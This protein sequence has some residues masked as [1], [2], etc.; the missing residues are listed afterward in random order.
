MRW[1][2][3]SFAWPAAALLAL[4]C[5]VPRVG[6]QIR[7]G[8][9]DPW[10]LGKGDWIYIL[11]DASS[12]HGGLAGLMSYEKSK[13]VSYVI[14]KA[15]EG[16]SLYA[17]YGSVQFN[18]AAVTAAHNAGLK[19][20][21]YTRSYGTDIAGEKGV[22]DYVFNLGADGFVID[23]EI[24][25][26]SVPNNGT[27]A[28]NLCSSI[29]ASWPNKFLAHAPMPIISVHRSFPYKEFG[30]YC[31]AVMPQCYWVELGVTP[32][33]MVTWM[34]DE[35]R[36]W[37][38]SLTG[39]W[40]DS[41]KPLA[42]I[43]QGWNTT[44]AQITQFVNAL[45]SDANP[46]T[47]GGYRGVSYWRAALHTTDIWNAIGANS[48]GG[49][50]SAAPTLSAIGAGNISDSSAT[51][52]WTTDQNSDSL[53]E[54]GTT[55][56][57]GQSV[58]GGFCGVNHRLTLSGL[59]AATT[60]HYRVKSRNAFNQ[61]RVSG[62]FT[63]P[64]NPSGTVNDIIIDNG[65]PTV[66][67]SGSW[68]TATSSSDKYRTNYYYKTYLSAKGGYVNFVPTIVKA[69]NYQVY[70]WHPAGSNRATNAPHVIHYHGG[71]QTVYVNQALNGGKFNLLGTWNFAAGTAG[72]I[73]IT[74]GF[75]GELNVMADAIKLVYAPPVVAP[76]IT[77]QPQ[78][79][80][81][82]A[83]GTATFT[84]SATGTAPLS[85]QWRRNSVNISGASGSSYTRH[86]VQPGDAGNYSV[87]VTNAGGH[88][89]SGNAVLTVNVPP[90]ISAQPQS[91]TVNQGGT[92]L[93]S[94]TASGT[95]PLSY[96]WRRNEVNIPGANS[97]AYTCAG[98]QTGDAGDYSVLV[99]NVAGSITSAVA[100]LTVNLAPWIT[101]QPQDQTVNPGGTA[102]FTVSAAGTPPL[103]YQW[104]FNNVDLAGATGSSYTRNGVQPA[105]VGAY[106]VRVANMAGSV[107]SSNAWLALT[108]APFIT[109]QPE[110]VAVTQGSSATFM[111]SAVGTAP[112]SY[113]WRFNGTN[114]AGATGASYTRGAAL[115][116][117]A[118]AYSVLIT[119][120]VGS[121]LSSN[122][123]LTVNVPPGIAV[124]PQSQTVSAGSA[125][126][127]SVTATGTLPLAYQWHKDGNAIAGATT[128]VYALA[129]VL[130][131]DA[132]SYS[133][134]V[135]N[136]AGSAPSV[137]AQLIVNVPPVIS[138]QPQSLAVNPGSNATFTVIAS[139]T[140]PL[141]YQWQKNGANISGATGSSYTRVNVQPG[142]AGSYTVQ[143]TNMVG[144]ITSAAA[145][146][147]VN[148]APSIIAQPQ[149]Q[150]VKQGATA[151]FAV[152]A[153]GTSPLSYQWRF[154]S[155]DLAGATGSSYTRAAAQ[156]ADAGTYTVVVTNM[157]GRVT[158]AAAMLVVNVPPDIAVPPQSQAVVVGETAVFSVTATGTAPLYYQWRK[159]GGAIA[160]AT[161]AS[162]TLASAQ[163]AD[164]GNY[165]VV[166]TNMAGTVTS[167][168]AVL[169]VS[170]EGYPPV[171][172]GQPQS[173]T[174]PPGG[175]A[176]FSVTA[177]GSPELHYQW[178]FNGTGIAGATGSSYSW[179]HI[180]AADAGLY[181]VVVSNAYGRAASWE[182]SLTLTEAIVFQDDFE[183]CDLSGWMVA[184]SPA[185]ELDGSH[186]QNHTPGGGCSAR[187]SHS[188]DKM[189]HNWGV[190][191]AGRMRATW[192][193]YDAEQ[194]R[195]YAE[196]RAHTGAGYTDGSGM[197]QL[198]A[199]GK[200]NSV[201]L[202]GELWDA[203]KYQGR[204]SSGTQVGW[205]NLNAPG[206]P[207]RSTG[208]HKFEVERLADGTT[209]NFYVDGLL[210]RTITGATEAMIDSVL[211]GSAAMGSTEG[212]AWI[213][214][215]QVEYWDPPVIV[216]PPAGQTVTAGG[217]ATFSVVAGNTVLSYQWRLNGENLAGATTSS[218]T[219]ASAQGADAGSYTV[220]VANGA[221]PTVSS[222]AVLQVAPVIV[223][224]PA[225]QTQH[226]GGTASFAVVAAGQAPLN[227]QW[228]FNG[229][230]LP[231][232]TS[233]TCVLANVQLQD[234]GRYSVVVTNLAGTA[235]SAD[236]ILAIT[237]P[238]PP[239]IEGIHRLPGGQIRLQINGAPGH[240]IAEAS[241]NLLEWVEFTNLTVAGNSFQ[242]F[243]ST[244]NLTSRFYRVQLTP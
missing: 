150:T 169:M 232:A 68:L 137:N 36:N 35:W 173:L 102:V 47:V 219:V 52:S 143:V 153:V 1:H 240:Y 122:A 167:A 235:N 239:R 101:T 5:A 21:G 148:Q 56:A 25:W 22:A 156:P 27:V 229:N 131:A 111:V 236:A 53:V 107:I 120:A 118:G 41:I 49:A 98:V 10:N 67:V 165:S 9:I 94:V 77:T 208:W 45:K 197:Q 192:W 163:L 113:Q 4:C 144:S 42:P 79:Q 39:T 13:G 81:V 28:M 222:P 184:A 212:E 230:P 151:T 168:D 139:G 242:I 141:V 226:V 2:S 133:V 218:L 200:Y 51:I 75:T 178:R 210:G 43:A 82:T 138:G 174:C 185:T 216:T 17:P 177:S 164:A 205:F 15:G 125:A 90:T 123:L 105:D 55:T 114:L 140:A 95:A 135:S 215:V 31:D 69:G 149:N 187:V 97:S 84:V 201:T 211:I 243:D 181:S 198:F 88:V 146:L 103:S 46:V 170:A 38:N 78:D 159:N 221:G 57:Y 172:T 225:S 86:N 130:A 194:T 96:Q 171:I 189:Y 12:Q 124:Q 214:D 40:R 74:D 14:I 66:A 154:N 59:S 58:A 188:S 186:A 217:S 175:S 83:G 166:I 72:Y 73:Q 241:S 223:T 202:S 182:A 92:A 19:I 119:N 62:D 106:S 132:G 196:V 191:V 190:K 203:N 63:F 121:V 209:I 183:A 6:A 234:A 179:S 204:V 207:N 147:T 61:Q 195:V 129:N 76:T 100:V 87:V 110:D 115:P 23:A 155:V 109:A 152:S 161:A 193:I 26:E 142:D 224:Q 85:Y 33:Y 117:H 104:R 162:Y 99:V 37:Q 20:F 48:I 237:Q 206:A 213:D 145:V 18:S 136:V 44:G 54:Y 11:S 8:N 3:W 89:T 244:T 128:S 228:R 71:T 238:L 126:V 91:Q 127:F 50:Y 32:T 16:G 29:R 233:S 60:Y 220:V 30:Y 157:A 158:S 180:Q 80:E 160:G 134:V 227:Y 34:D 65:E 64:T 112:L 199:A 176:T 231:G 24:E 108:M 93:F 70:E 7:D 116:A